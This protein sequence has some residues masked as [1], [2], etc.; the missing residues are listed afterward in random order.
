M[1]ASLQTTPGTNPQVA[2][3]FAL[4]I[5]GWWR[6]L[7]AVKQYRTDVEFQKLRYSMMKSRGT[8]RRLQGK[9]DVPDPTRKPIPD[10]SE[11][12]LPGGVHSVRDAIWI[13][14]Q[15]GKDV[16]RWRIKLQPAN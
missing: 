8:L 13:S 10:N 11:P 7:T 9:S 3:C 16:A 6:M 2:G 1:L 14:D 12:W 15:I 5:R 4:E